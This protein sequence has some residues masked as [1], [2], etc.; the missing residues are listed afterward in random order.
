MKDAVRRPDG[1]GPT[2]ETTLSNEQVVNN[3]TGKTFSMKM[4]EAVRLQSPESFDVE[5]APAEIDFNIDKLEQELDVAIA[6]EFGDEPRDN[7]GTVDSDT[8]VDTTPDMAT[9][10]VDEVDREVDEIAPT[11]LQDEPVQADARESET[12]PRPSGDQGVSWSTRVM[13]LSSRPF[14]ALPPRVQR[15]VQLSAVSMAVWVPIVW[16]MVVTDG[17]GWLVS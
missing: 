15:L 10:Q 4:D 6:A 5:E 1:D 16:L 2:T 7:P 14:E 12:T 8:V 9:Q 17:I 13:G 3:K 11:P